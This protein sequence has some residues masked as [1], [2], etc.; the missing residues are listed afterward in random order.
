MFFF[1]A[2]I[3]DPYFWPQPFLQGE[4]PAIPYSAMFR[5]PVGQ[6]AYS[7]RVTK[8]SWIKRVIMTVWAEWGHPK[9]NGI[10]FQGESEGV[11][12]TRLDAHK[13]Q[14]YFYNVLWES[15][16]WHNQLLES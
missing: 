8:E 12:E 2:D 7:N 5:G 3:P 13:S 6:K 15:A 16:L 14:N 10:A 1:A 9:R 11:L 4:I